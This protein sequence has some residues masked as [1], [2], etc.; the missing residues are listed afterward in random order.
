MKKQMAYANS[1]NIPFVALVGEQEI[2]EGVITL[3]EMETGR[4]ERLTPDQLV[5]HLDSIT[6]L[7][8]NKIKRGN[9]HDNNPYYQKSE[10]G[11]PGNHQ[12]DRVE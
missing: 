10:K 2:S 7:P 11:A 6:G 3:K 5:E 1:R 12:R 8:K 9:V 4:Q